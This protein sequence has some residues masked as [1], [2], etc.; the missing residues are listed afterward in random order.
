MAW[1]LSGATDRGAEHPRWDLWTV[2]SD[3]LEG[4]EIMS[5]NDGTAFEYRV[6]HRVYKRDVWYVATRE[7]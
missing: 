1:A 3:R 4:Y 2:W 5:F 7:R 6:Y